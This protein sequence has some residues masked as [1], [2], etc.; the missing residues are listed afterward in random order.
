[1][2]WS[3]QLLQPAARR[4]HLVSWEAVAAGALPAVTRS[5]S[6]GLV[7][8]SAVLSYDGQAGQAAVTR[9]DDAL[10]PRSRARPQIVRP[11]PSAP[12]TV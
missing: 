5:R 1:M 4:V 2:N 11:S 9:R 8:L 10:S 7:S 12:A 6:A 3:D